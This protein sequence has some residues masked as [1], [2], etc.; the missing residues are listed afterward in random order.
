MVDLWQAGL[1]FAAVLG[2]VIFVFE[3]DRIRDGWAKKQEA[4]EFLTMVQGEIEE[5]YNTLKEIHHKLTTQLYFMPYY[6]LR[7]DIWHAL[8]GRIALLD[9]SDLRKNILATAR[10]KN[11]AHQRHSNERSSSQQ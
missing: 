10:D 11:R 6:G 3:F 5:D 4:I 2:G 9:N 8:S 7:L 1:E